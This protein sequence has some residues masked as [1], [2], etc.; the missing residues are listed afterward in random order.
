M[1]LKAYAQEL[2][3]ENGGSGSYG[4]R[5]A[6]QMS[7]E[8][9]KALLSTGSG[10]TAPR[11]AASAAQPSGSMTEA[12]KK[13]LLGLKDEDEEE[14]RRRELY[15]QQVLYGADAAQALQGTSQGGR[16]T[17]AET[18]LLG[19][20]RGAAGY[21]AG[22]ADK[23]NFGQA[24]QTELYVN[25]QD[26][27]RYTEEEIQAFQNT[28]AD[29]GELAYTNIGL[30][31]ALIMDR[32][33]KGKNEAERQQ[34]ARE[35][36][37]ELT[38]RTKWNTE[39]EKAWQEYLA[40]RDEGER[41][42]GSVAQQIGRQLPSMAVSMAAGRALGALGGAMGGAEGAAAGISLG[43]NIGLGAMGYS[44]AGSAAQEAWQKAKEEGREISVR[45][46]Y[47]VGVRK[48]MV[49]VM[50]EKMFGGIAAYGEGVVSTALGNT[51]S[52]FVNSP[53]G[54]RV[55]RYGAQFLNSKAGKAVGAVADILGENIEE[56]VSDFFS[57]RIENDVLGTDEHELT[58]WEALKGQLPFVTE[59]GTMTLITSLI[60]GSANM[61]KTI[62]EGGSISKAEIKQAVNEQVDEWKEKWGGKQAEKP[63]GLPGTNERSVL[64]NGESIGEGQGER[65]DG[66]R[67]GR[68]AGAVSAERTE[69]GALGRAA[70]ED[71]QGL[72]DP[73]RADL[74]EVTPAELGIR[75]GSGERRVTL[76]DA[77][78][79]SRESADAAAKIRQR[80]FEPVA[81]RGEMQVGRGNVNG[82]I[83]DG[84]VYYSVDATD[85]VGRS[86]S[87]SRIV[88]HELF[89]ER[90]GW[91][92]T[93]VA[94]TTNRIRGLME[95]ST[96]NRMKDA[97]M[98][99]YEKV[100]DFTDWTPVQIANY[101]EE[102]LCAD[103]YA[104][105]NWFSEGY[106]DAITAA[107]AEYNESAQAEA[108]AR[109]G[110]AGRGRALIVNLPDGSGRQYVQA[111]RQVIYGNDPD[112]WG[113]QIQEYI[114]GKI[115]HGEDVALTTNDGDVLLITSD[116]SGKAAFRNY[117]RNADGTLR[118]LTDEE[119]LTKINAEA[120]IDE[121]AQI[122]KKVKR[123]PSKDELGI[124]GELAR[125]GW[126]YRRA[127]F[128]DSDGQYYM[129][130]ISTPSGAKGVTVY[131]VGQIE[132]RSFPSFNGSSAANSGARTGNASSGKTVPQG[133]ST[134]KGKNGRSS[135]NIGSELDTLRQELE[136]R[137]AAFREATA[138]NDPDY[139]YPGEIQRMNALERQIREQ[140]Q[141][142][143]LPS[144]RAEAETGETPNGLPS[145]AQAAQEREDRRLEYLR[146]EA[147]RERQRAAENR[148]RENA[149]LT[150]ELGKAAAQ[151]A[152]PGPHTYRFEG[153][154][155]NSYAIRTNT[156]QDGIV[157]M[158][159]R[160]N[161]FGGRTLVGGQYADAATAM[162]AAREAIEGSTTRS[163]DN[164]PG[165]ETDPVD[166]S[167]E[168]PTESLAQ[169]TERARAEGYPQIEDAEGVKHQAVPGYTWVK[170]KDRGNY[171][172]VVGK[173]ADG[174]LQV[175]FINKEEGTSRTVSFGPA[176]VEWVQGEYST[177]EDVPAYGDE[178]SMTDAEAAAERDAVIEETLAEETEANRRRIAERE[179]TESEEQP[180]RALR[181]IKAP[182]RAELEAK[183]PIK[184]V[185]IREETTGN[186]S[187]QRRAFLSS[188]EAKNLYET[189]VRNS[190][191]GALLFITPKTVTHSFSNEG[192]ENILAVKH[193][194]E[195]IENAVFTHAEQS[196]K[197]PDD[198]STGVYKFF[199]AVQT[200]NGI[201]PVKLTVK[202]YRLEGQDVPASIKKYTDQMQPGDTFAVTYDGKV[203]VLEEIEKE[204]SSSAPSSTQEKPGPDKHP[205]VS[206]Y[207][208]KDLLSLVKGDDAKYIPPAISTREDI[209]LPPT[210]EGTAREKVA[211]EAGRKIS[212]ELRS[213]AEA[214]SERDLKAK[215]RETENEIRTLEKLGR[216]AGLTAAQQTELN[217]L[218]GNLDMYR[219]V[220]QEKKGGTTRQKKEPGKAEPKTAR[221]EAVK[222]ILERF[223]IQAANNQEARGAIDRALQRIQERGKVTEQDRKALFDK[224]ID[225]GI[226]KQE[227]DETFRGIRWDLKGRAVYVPQNV[228]HDFGDNWAE[229][230]KLAHSAGFYLTSNQSDARIDAV[231]MELADSYGEGLFPT[232]VSTTEMLENMIEA[233]DKGKPHW[234][235]LQD[236]LAQMAAE[237][238][239]DI[240]DVLGDEMDWL[241]SE[242]RAF[243]RS[244][245]MEMELRGRRA[246]SELKAETLKKVKQ[247]QNAAKKAGPEWRAKIN[248]LVGDI[249]TM[250]RRISA[251][252]LE[253]LQALA[254][255]YKRM[256]TAAG[257]VDADNP[258][259]WT[260]RAW[261]EERLARLE[262]LH[263]D[264]LS[265]EQV[266]E[267]Q[268]TVS[269]MLTQM[270]NERQLV[271]E[272]HRRMIADAAESMNDEIQAARGV[273]K[274]RLAAAVERWFSQEQLGGRR[275]LMHLVG[276]HNGEMARQVEALENGGTRK[277]DYQMRA[278]GMFQNFVKEHADWIR[279][280]SGKAAQGIEYDVPG[281]IEFNEDGTA[282]QIETK[283]IT[284][285]PMMRVALLMHS[286]NMDNLHHI[287]QGGIRV[288][289][290]NL[291]KK[292]RIEEA[293]KAGEIIKMQPDTVRTIVK[294]CTAEERA[295]A[296]LLS[297]YGDGMA[298]DAINEVSLQLD[299]FERAG[300]G[301]YWALES[302]QAF[303]KK[304]VGREAV[305]GTVEGIGSIA[306]E[307]V[308]GAGNPVRL[309]DAMDTLLRN[310]D[311]VGSYYGYAIPVHNF[312]EI[313]NHTFHEKGKSF[314]GSI[315][316]SLNKKWG[317]GTTGYIEKLIADVQNRN[318]GTNDTLGRLM[319]KVR[320]GAAGA[321]LTF[322]P[323]V[324][325]S[326]FASYPGAAQTLG[327]DALGH[328]LAGK[329]DMDLVAK[330]TPVLW[331]RRNSDMNVLQG[332]GE[333]S[334]AKKAP[335]VFDWISA[336]DEFTIKR[337]WSA[338]EYA[339]TRD[340]KMTKADGDAYY[341][342]V[343]EMFN[344][345]VY[346]TQPNYT[347]FQRSQILR[348][349]NQLVK[350]LTMFKTVGQ[351]YYGMMFEAAG[352]LRAAQAEYK[353]N[354][355]TESRQ[356][357]QEAQKYA[358]RT[359]SG[360]IVGNLMFAA[361][362]GLASVLKK[363][364][365][366]Y[367]D[368]EGQLTT[369]S[370]AKGVFDLTAETFA[371]SAM[372]GDQLYTLI[373]SK[374]RGEKWYG[375]EVSSVS[376][377]TENAESLS[378]VISTGVSVLQGDASYQEGLGAIHDMAEGIAQFFGF[379]AGNMEDWLLA[380]TKWI[381]PEWAQ[382]YES[383]FKDYDK[384]SLKKLRSGK[385]LEAGV[386]TL[387]D[388]RGMEAGDKT[389]S[390]LSRLYAAGYTAAVPTA[391]P[392]KITWTVNGEQQEVQLGRAARKEYQ[393]A[394]ND[395]V[396]VNALISSAGYRKAADK[397][398]AQMLARLYELG[399]ETARAAAADEYSP[400]KWVTDFRTAE[401]SGITA[402]DYLDW[403]Y[404]TK[405][406]QADKDA[407]GS[408]VSGTAKI[409]KLQFIDG[410]DLGKKQ[411]D[412]L[413]KLAGYGADEIG[414]APWNCKYK[415]D[416]WL[417]WYGLSDSS[418]EAYE[419]TLRGTGMK[420]STYVD[421]YD[422]YWNTSADKD[423]NGN[424]ISG[425][426]KAKIVE[427]IN[428]LGISD[429]QKQALYSVWYKGTGPWGS[430]GLPSTRSTGSRVLD[431]AREHYGLPSTRGSTARSG[432]NSLPSTQSSG[433][434]VL[435]YAREHFGL[436]STR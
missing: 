118:R 184:V 126:L 268:E 34:I 416:D 384:G 137:Q 302:D 168:R 99:A 313:Y 73:A 341:Q 4:R 106:E 269:A 237:G 194:R 328:G 395:V 309:Y 240:D 227:A 272:G 275:F 171:G 70:G 434:R 2:L 421:A 385:D 422:K 74:R 299:G 195:I 18:A 232:D 229:Y 270:Q 397:Q 23:W 92:L 28:D 24:A 373:E 249:D 351:Q 280:A 225:L 406:I 143:G 335:A 146:Q 214:M 251:A 300:V 431:Y 287:E 362:K 255:Q 58:A 179:R 346:D 3:K 222:N 316:E 253:N 307:R 256:R 294:D 408:P 263:I 399:T 298:K 181:D 14:K 304:D 353:A 314:S 39:R 413:Y 378:K 100:E 257:S 17:D 226:V 428:G 292:G 323:S 111:D 419:T 352:R 154:N 91:D 282:A 266:A 177:A 236:S 61:M 183:K 175:Q 375:P 117:V 5:R 423:A 379:P 206:T 369:R 220:Q 217:R 258:G 123:N 31:T 95:E 11:A 180:Q 131:N 96:F 281:V 159:V 372:F 102:E 374:M 333:V 84:R 336:I 200:E 63:A 424:S 377:F 219:E 228:R 153:P 418:R 60:L 420:L 367:R 310:I 276:Y 141:P 436:P 204:T 164:R 20:G 317:E 203:L 121:L 311:N 410:M 402:P 359:Y 185:D 308:K 327:W 305:A 67:A 49:E 35:R 79:Y 218:R 244:A 223:S 150:E 430:G 235:S 241:D 371:G 207:S 230:Q 357:L 105:I 409:K 142:A 386:R 265:L 138:R 343:A 347:P 338:A 326:Q 262:K 158:S 273:G 83:Q 391:I 68:E 239:I 393:N 77:G 233:A 13:Y 389:V 250:S 198:H 435:D 334:L 332:E 234:V 76:V 366:K 103:A 86:L 149:R 407:D 381:A 296:E 403:Y 321:T 162:E 161:G 382:K 87:P 115:R 322:N 277:L 165:R 122:S 41:R 129:V 101:L 15:R 414:D 312:N 56:A 349:D 396:D 288:P 405:D 128:M 285:T 213:R 32:A 394:W 12:Y 148:E 135:L 125:N 432:G 388:V 160:E 47:E 178:P 25:G 354:A 55:L 59:E 205:S 243:A 98:R 116:T 246:E 53:A 210:K 303:T 242:L 390:E 167:L 279:T 33:T 215:I 383:L 8:Y 93:L 192:Q 238:R 30:P 247:L 190:D 358:A 7:Q 72:G 78:R 231:T 112:S 320:S 425:S 291:Y 108:G 9:K 97:Y 1:D 360:L 271:E 156:Y 301:N 124:H 64:N 211:D 368:E 120:H 348:S 133:K 71:G 145:A 188:D 350:S 109:E 342:Q 134:V 40:S 66:L 426:K 85:A 415:G 157:M 197:A 136:E 6:Q 433:S 196:I 65:A 19:T 21:A 355:S 113:E 110:A 392:A 293:Y 139:D 45:D 42:L 16:S 69:E 44:A 315:K 104:G 22:A 90:A 330:Y 400:D 166:E 363:K 187:E 176:A 329:V 10:D 172:R 417:L 221:R 199:G 62:Q 290:W 54:E 364:D 174:S 286:R 75:Q 387:C 50:S 191:T 127:F 208:V 261:M 38:S 289:D 324:A 380:G 252:G 284:I 173:N 48:G 412:A 81:F 339:V 345:A 212:E 398:K 370:F 361:L 163:R 94:R 36:I 26:H 88:D 401:R 27:G 295:F 254:E 356:Q 37:E 331:S 189:P 224:L 283:H 274:G 340:T 259:N 119:Y 114:N 46:A 297:K 147:E 245:G 107:Q 52:D 170:A 130:T 337:L 43:Q 89:H 264:D 365:D 267:L 169:A 404:G 306:N 411:K 29:K 344:R 427:Y 201:Q 319:A 248:D 132:R 193:L 140:E 216:R 51:I 186:R 260:G 376:W 80:G 202:E 325:L 182:S 57:T 318:G 152:E 144:T 82:Y 155:G 429:E 278:I 151:A 209:G